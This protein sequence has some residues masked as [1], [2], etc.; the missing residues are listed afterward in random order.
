VALKRGV[1]DDAPKSSPKY[2][3]LNR[4]R[5]NP[6]RSAMSEAF[7]AA[8]GI[9]QAVERLFNDVQFLQVES[10]GIAKLAEIVLRVRDSVVCWPVKFT[11]IVEDF[12]VVKQTKSVRLRVPVKPSS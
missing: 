3:F 1:E 4:T 6:R 12:D 11:D 10:E 5:R 9:R 2:A 7:T 8:R